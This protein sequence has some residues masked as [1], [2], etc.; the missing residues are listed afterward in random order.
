MQTPRVCLATVPAA[1]VHGR[2]HHVCK[3]GS[4][5]GMIVADHGQPLAGRCVA[6][7]FSGAPSKAQT[8]APLPLVSSSHH[9]LHDTGIPREGS[10]CVSWG[11]DGERRERIARSKKL[12]VAVAGHAV[13]VIAPEAIPASRIATSGACCSRSAS[14]SA[15][16]SS[17]GKRSRQSRSKLWLAISSPFTYART[18][19]PLVSQKPIHYRRH[20]TS[21]TSRTNR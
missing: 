10:S 21:A 15:K 11:R 1:Q 3:V 19:C 6:N 17:I 7:G 5:P 12:L 8:G 4:T 13:T 16:A 14:P 9:G 20:A 2:G 18:S